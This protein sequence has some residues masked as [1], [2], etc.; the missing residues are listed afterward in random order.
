[1][2]AKKIKN[3]ISGFHGHYA[4]WNHALKNEYELG[5]NKY[6]SPESF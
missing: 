2:T 6:T 1:M 4:V 5:N 3:G